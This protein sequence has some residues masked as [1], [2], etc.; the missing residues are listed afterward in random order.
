MFVV[1]LPTKKIY[2]FT[3]KN[4]KRVLEEKPRDQRGITFHE[5]LHA[6]QSLKLGEDKVGGLVGSSPI[7]SP[8]MTIG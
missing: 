4:N 7:K 5:L 1:G 8:F 6:L 3:E 2:F